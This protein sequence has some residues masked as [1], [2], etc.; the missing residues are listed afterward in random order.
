MVYVYVITCSFSCNGC[1]ECD[2]SSSKC[3]AI[4]VNEGKSG[5]SLCLDLLEFSFLERFKPRTRPSGTKRSGR[6]VCGTTA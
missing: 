5:R 3:N 1:F 4:K 6:D 2:E